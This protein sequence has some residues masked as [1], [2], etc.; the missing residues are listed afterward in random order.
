MFL[1]EKSWMYYFKLWS[2]IVS[3]LLFVMY[4]WINLY[5]LL[6]LEH[7]QV[8]MVTVPNK[9]MS[10]VGMLIKYVD[11]ICPSQWKYCHHLVQWCAIF[12]TQRAILELSLDNK[13]I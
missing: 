5:L 12:S 9:A 1:L 2:V 10:L 4:F 3:R 8:E 13:L 6:Y 7:K 11:K